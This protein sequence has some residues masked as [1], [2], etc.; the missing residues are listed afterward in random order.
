MQHDMRSFSKPLRT[1]HACRLAGLLGGLLVAAVPAGWGAEL[2]PLWSIGQVD[3]NNAELALAPDGYARFK[4]DPFFIVGV[5]D[6]KREWPYAQPGPSDSWAGQR[7]H[8][9]T[10]RFGLAELPAEG[11]C[12][13]E[14]RLLDTHSGGAPRLRVDVNGQVT[15]H[16]LPRGGGDGSIQ[17]HPDQ[18]NRTAVNVEFP[19][20]QLHV[21]DNDIQL[22]TLSGSWLLYDA[23]VLLAPEGAQVTVPTG[24]TAVL[25]ADVVRALR[26]GAAGSLTQPLKVV[27]RHL[28]EPAGGSLEIDGAVA[29]SIQLQRGD[30]EFQLRLPEVQETRTR[31]LILRVGGEVVARREVTVPPFRELTVYILPHSHTDIGYTEIQTDI[32]EKQVNNLLRGME[33]A[34]ATADYPDGARF[35]WNVE[36][37]WAA[38]LYLHR[39]GP[40][41]RERFLEAVR[42]GKVA[43]NGL[44]LNELTGLCRPE[45]LLRLCRLATQLGDTTGVAVDA[46]MISDVPG[47]TWG[48]VTAMAQAGIRYFSVAPNY[49]DRIGDI[50]VQW[51]NKPFYWVGPSGRDKVLVWI[52]WRGYAMSHIIHRLTPE[53]VTEYQEQ[54][55]RSGF[56]YDIAYMRWAGHGDN[57]VPDP[58]IC[59]FIRDW[60]TEYAWPHFN[61]TSTSAAF[62]DFEERYGDRLPEVAGDWTP[63]WE[64]GAGSSALETGLNRESSDRLAQAETLWALR[65]P[66]PYPVADFSTAWRDTLLYSEHTWGAWCSVSEPA[67]QETLDQWAI[68]SSYAAAADR[69]SRD[70]LDR[71]GSPAPGPEAEQGIDLYNTT[72]WARTEL[73]NVPHDFWD[74]RSRVLDSAGNPVPSQRLANGDLVML[75]RDAPPLA[76]RRYR[77]VNGAP[78]AG[79]AKAEADAA[80]AVLRN[81]RLTVRLDPT[82][83]AIID[84]RVT[85]YDHNLVDTSDGEGLGDCR[86]LIGDDLANL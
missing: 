26:R 51:E 55:E 28:G 65:G 14:L 9:F 52:P 74:G 27:L 53:F 11:T 34:E 21:G 61:I 45:E 5:S 57:A 47:Y 8:T 66:G 58:A 16:A 77:F 60:N 39:L 2:V 20:T 69:E 54:L 6:P 12:R 29:R 18:G 82:T 70:L 1:R 3:G 25:R 63:Y 62:R 85:G 15:E 73:A 40:A 80:E 35:V 81:E 75:V 17:G 71:A 84:L 79:E 36:V 48:T 68:K 41:Q 50:L 31:R 42:T 33:L 23:V 10:I 24:Q 7:R 43:L 46:A 76:A 67:R 56:P 72:S 59:E 4:E 30:Q 44:Y 13:L 83:G 38:D 49:F 22:T 32:E 78:H 37:L 19:V 64:D 86:Y